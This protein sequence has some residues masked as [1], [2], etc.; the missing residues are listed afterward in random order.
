MKVRDNMTDDIYD[1]LA[2]ALD[3]ASEW[4]SQDALEHRRRYLKKIFAPEEA[5]LAAQLCGES[6]PIDVARRTVRAAG[7]RGHVP[8]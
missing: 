3:Q 2:N 7:R 4:F 6:E 1:Q 8:D 5:A